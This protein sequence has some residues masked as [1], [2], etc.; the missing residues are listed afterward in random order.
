LIEGLKVKVAFRRIEKANLLII[1]LFDRSMLSSNSVPW[2]L[3]LLT[4]FNINL[5]L[6]S[7]PEFFVGRFDYSGSQ[8]PSLSLSVK[9]FPLSK[10]RELPLDSIR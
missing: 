8:S 10:A 6:V 3:Y 7:D 4:A 2:W 5:P 9:F 1:D